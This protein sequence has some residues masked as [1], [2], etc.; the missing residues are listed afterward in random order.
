MV[1]VLGRPDSWNWLLFGHLVFAF[2]LVGGVLVVV[3]ASLAAPHLPAQLVPLR[4]VAFW[5]NLAVVLPSF[6]GTYV[7]GGVLETKEYDGKDPRWLEAAFRITDIT[8]VF[9]GVLLTVL[10]WW[11]RKRAL[12][13]AAG[14]WQAKLAQAAPP[15]V[16]AALLAVVFLMAGKPT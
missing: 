5:A 14:G 11:V 7:L 15:L 2:L 9:G 10:L 16:L 4:S 3:M 13:G 1:A 6:I 12:A 8:L